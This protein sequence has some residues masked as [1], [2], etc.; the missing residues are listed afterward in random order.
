ME[1]GILIHDLLSDIRY[2]DDVKLV[3]ENAYL[4]GRINNLEKGYYLKLLTEVVQHDLLKPYFN[5]HTTVYNEKEILIPNESFIRPDRIIKVQNH[6]AIIDYKTGKYNL[7]HES[8]INRYAQ[9]INEM[10]NEDCK[11][12]LVYINKRISVKQIS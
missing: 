2:E 5:K 10:Y 12:F 6:W 8:Q 11:K 9:I 3:I 1:E 7:K 4:I